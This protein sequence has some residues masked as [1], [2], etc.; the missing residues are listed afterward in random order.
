MPLDKSEY[1]AD[2]VCLSDGPSRS[3]GKQYYWGGTEAVFEYLNSELAKRVTK[4]NEG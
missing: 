4:N 3:K 1:R 2:R